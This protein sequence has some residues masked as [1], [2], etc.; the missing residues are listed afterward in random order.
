[1]SETKTVVVKD[2]KLRE[3]YE[4][5]RTECEKK[6]KLASLKYSPPMNRETK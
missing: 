2:G 3:Y 5:L 6:E 4:K 1:M